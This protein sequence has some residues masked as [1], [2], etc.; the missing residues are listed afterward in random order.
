MGSDKGY[1]GGV[2]SCVVKMIILIMLRQI[3][4][5]QLPLIFHWFSYYDP[6]YMYYDID[7]DK[8]SFFTI[9]PYFHRTREDSNSKLCPVQ[10]VLSSEDPFS[11]HRHCP[12]WI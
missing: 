12:H 11:Y 5:I 8:R 2:M 1:M 9:L 7:Q 4:L 10:R 3:L 6:H